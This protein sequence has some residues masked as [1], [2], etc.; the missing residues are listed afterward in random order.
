MAPGIQRSRNGRVVAIASRSLPKAREFAERFDVARAYGSYA[1]LLEDPGVEA[2]YVPLPN[3]LHREWTIRAAEKGKHVLC[4]KPFACNAQEAQQMVDACHRNGVI[5]MEGFTQ[6]FQPQNVRAKKLIDDGRIG[7]V[8]WMT[9]IHSG[10]KPLP[11]DPRL[12]KELCQT[13]LMEK[14]CYCVDTARYIFGAEPASVYATAELGEESGV[15]E[16][17]TATLNFPGG[18]V[19]QFDCSFQLIEGSYFH[20]YHVFGERGH[21]FVPRGLTQLELYRHGTLTG[22][23]LS[24]TDNS[25]TEVIEVPA[26]HRWRVEAEYFADGV[27]MGEDIAYPHEDGVAN[28]KVIDAIY[29]SVKSGQ[30]ATV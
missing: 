25:G 29:A 18:G 16:R 8:L 6:R 13:I 26:M 22:D 11:G 21:I 27:L 14:G 1:A 12:S 7:R 23:S 24:V 15:D 2:V 17:V 3:S 19:A 4:E 9:A 20:S 30:V 5:V 10:E 28:M